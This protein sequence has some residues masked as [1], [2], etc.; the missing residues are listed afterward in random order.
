MSPGRIAIIG[1]GPGGLTLARILHISG[2][3]VVIYE[4]EAFGGVRP[5]GGSH[6]IHADSGLYALKWQICSRDFN[7]SHATKTKK[8]AFIANTRNCYS[9]T[10]RLPEKTVQKWT[11]DT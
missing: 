11:A 4:R 8:S 6:D 3:D 9:W 1:A 2:L 7:E 5:Q 10:M